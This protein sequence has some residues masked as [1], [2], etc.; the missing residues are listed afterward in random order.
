M[1]ERG[2]WTLVWLGVLT[3][4]FSVWGLWN[5]SSAEVV[6]A[7]LLVLV[8]ILGMALAWLSPTVRSSLFQGASLLGALAAVLIPRGVG[9][10]LRQYYDT[11]SAAF[12]HVAANALL[13]GADPYTTSMSA[14]APLLNNPAYYWTY[15]ATGSHVAHVSYPAGSFLLDVPALAL[16]LQH[17]TVDWMD[18]FAWMVA[19]VM[20]FALLP[21]SLRWLGGLVILTPVFSAAF[22]AGGT[23]AAFLPFL[24]L[25]LWRWDRFGQG[26]EAGVARWLGPVALGLACA[27][28]Q[29]P[30]F[31]LPFLATGIFLEARSRGAGAARLLL[32]YVSMAAAAFVAVNIPFILWHP[33]AWVHGTLLP[34]VEPLVA[35]GQG[36]VSLATHGITGGVDLSALTWAAGLAYLAVFAAF[37][38]R[39]R[40][41]KRIWPLL[42]PVA[43]FFSTRSLANYLVDLFPVAV[44][45]LATVA[46]APRPRAAE[47]HLAVRRGW[48][49]PTLC[50]GLP[51]VGVVVA[52][53][54][55]FASPPLQISVK[56]VYRSE[57]GGFLGSVKVTVYNR[58]DSPVSP[59]F[60]VDT[61]E[62]HPSG[63]WF[64]ATGQPLVLGPHA[65]ATFRLRPPEDV[66]QPTVG[67]LWL[68][69]AYTSP[70][71]SMSTSP[72]QQWRGWTLTP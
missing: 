45:A 70:P 56:A 5:A 15:T 58:T 67:T 39:Y 31:C 66:D 40:E 69:Q 13:H 1:A 49:F 65:S 34:F 28:K 51:A 60:L 41:L 63:F 48:L 43:F 72:L 38:V 37:V 23:D 54:L 22:S 12:D 9:I 30:W 52:S 71:T 50:I 20:L 57:F 44:V 29:T 17:L 10:H 42:L 53:A 25:A 59:H 14:A 11:D 2:A 4:G 7:P 62:D 46:P 19:G 8:G 21:A 3:G 47:S 27:I 55:A 16:G 35:D 61:G 18:L 24:V 6:L 68:V 26:R 33:G 36:L 32:R 64:S